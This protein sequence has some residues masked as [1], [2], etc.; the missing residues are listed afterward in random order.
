MS[1]LSFDQGDDE[2]NL[3]EYSLPNLDEICDQFVE[4]NL[5]PFKELR[6]EC[7]REELAKRNIKRKIY[8]EW[9]AR[10]QAKSVLKKV[11]D[12]LIVENGLVHSGTRH[13]IGPWMRNIDIESSSYSPCYPG[14]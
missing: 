1:K 6:S 10:R 8:G 5:V 13:S 11:F 7:E 3:V 9:Q 12:F 2:C 14:N 4:H